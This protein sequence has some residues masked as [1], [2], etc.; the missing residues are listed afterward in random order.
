ML[1]GKPTITAPEGGQADVRYGIITITGVIS[2]I[3]G[4]LPPYYYMCNIILM[5]IREHYKH[6]PR[7]WCHYLHYAPYL[8]LFLLSR[9]ANAPFITN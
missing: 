2:Q 4:T 3:H 6:A 8:Q 7:V 9:P 5:R 1:T